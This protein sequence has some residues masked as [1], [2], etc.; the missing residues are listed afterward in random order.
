MKQ[1]EE[2]SSY[3]LLNCVK[4]MP[5]LTELHFTDVTLVDTQNLT[6]DNPD[7]NKFIGQ[8]LGFCRDYRCILEEGGDELQ[9]PKFVIDFC[10]LLIHSNIK[11]IRIH[12]SCP[13]DRAGIRYFLLDEIALCLNI[14]EKIA[15]AYPRTK[16]N[17]VTSLDMTHTYAS[18]YLHTTIFISRMS[19]LGHLKEFNISHNGLGEQGL[20]NLLPILRG[21]LNLETLDISNNRISLEIIMRENGLIPVLLRLR[22][23]KK[24]YIGYNEL[25]VNDIDV[26]KKA[27]PGVEVLALSRVEV[28]EN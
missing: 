5:K 16:I 24:L 12:E 7:D 1:A 19:N 2:L 4:N 6:D 23:L 18:E 26:I 8:F 15:L 21:L 25:S 28:L 3:P 11:T 20:N 17:R 27:L 13:V 14:I 22:K 10:G 9:L